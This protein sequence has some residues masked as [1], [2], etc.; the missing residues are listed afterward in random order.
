M[1][2]R[3]VNPVIVLKRKELELSERRLLLQRQE[4]R[5]MELEEEKA[6]AIDNIEASKAIVA[7]FEA[8]IAELKKI[9]V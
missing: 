8:D 4:L 9:S 2:D 1:A 7:A 5:L 3:K 6:T